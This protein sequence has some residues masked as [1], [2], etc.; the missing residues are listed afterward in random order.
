MF[1]DSHN[2]LD[3]AS[4][5]AMI[6]PAML[7][8]GKAA[9]YGLGWNV[10]SYLGQERISHG[11]Q[12][13]GFR[14]EWERYTRQR[15]SIIVIANLGSARVERLV[16]KIAGFYSPELAAPEFSASAV[17]PADSFSVGKQGI[18]TVVVRSVSRSAPDSVLELEIW[19]QTNKAVGKRNRTAE[20]FLK[21]QSKT[22]EFTWTPVKAGKYTVSLGIYGPKWN[23]SYSWSQGMATITVE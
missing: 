1:L 17:T 9:S 21:G 7:L 13:P 2:P 22:Y 10:D 8:D 23:P 3:A 11:G 5:T 14:S 20:N 4:R 16:P 19:D 15:L 12:Y 6:T 18:I